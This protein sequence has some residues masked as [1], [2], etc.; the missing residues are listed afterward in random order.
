MCTVKIGAATAGRK[1]ARKRIIPAAI[2]AADDGRPTIECIHPNKYPHTGPNPR[3][4]YAY[5]PPASGIA[6][7]NSAYESAPN[8]D[9]NPPTIH[10]TNTTEMLRPSRAI[11]AGFRNIPV[12]II[13]PTTMA[14]EAHGPSPR[15]SSRR[16]S[17]IPLPLECGGSPPL[18][19]RLIFTSTCH[20]AITE[21]CNRPSPKFVI[22][23]ALN[24]F[25]E[26]S[27]A[28]DLLFLGSLQPVRILKQ[29]PLVPETPDWRSPRPRTSPTIQSS[30]TT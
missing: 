23:P 4:R 18:F 27:E 17:L 29:H 19:H 5:S 22:P 9:S 26:G 25:S 20:R 21:A 28:R 12:P 10:A 2:D 1:N 3:R 7:P 6:A 15:T 13:V 8:S 24:A 14:A 16:F 30:S 11:S